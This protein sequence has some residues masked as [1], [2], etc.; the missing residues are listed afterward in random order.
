MSNL[1]SPQPC[2]P[3]LKELYVG[4]CHKLKRFISGSASNDFPNLYLLIINGASKLEEL[5]GCG[6]EKGDRIEKKKVELPRVK[7]LIFMHMSNFDQEIELPSLKI[8]VVYKS[9]KLSLTPTTTFGELKETFPYKDLKNTGLLDWDLRE[10]MSYLDEDSSISGSSEFTS[11]Q[12]IGN[13]GN[14]SIKEGP[15]TKGDKTKPLSTGVEDI[16]IG[17]G[18]ATHIDSV[19][20][21]Y[22]H[23]IPSLEVENFGGYVV[24]PSKE[25]VDN[26]TPQREKEF[27]KLYEEAV[28]IGFESSWIDEM[29]QHI[30]TK[31]PKLREDIA[32]R[33]KD[34]N[35]KS[36]LSAI[37]F[38][39]NLPFK[40]VTLSDG[41][42][43]IIEIMQQEFPSIACSFKQGF[44]TNEKLAELEARGNEMATTLGSK[45]S[46][47]RI[48]MMKLNRRK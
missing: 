21:T 34:E 27:H 12:E 24:V 8:C 41:L 40:D 37:N 48:S 23:N 45:I 35:P 17:G 3:K 16:S 39:S 31:D 13:I 26:V 38:S 29:R 19:A 33:Q 11:P 25:S 5:V 47:Q 2:F 1:L 18:V 6:Q 32:G 42:K 7:L 20:W 28:E 10:Y 46:R 44:A 43:D 15:S 4:H 9:P 36:L 14:E 30:L 22:L